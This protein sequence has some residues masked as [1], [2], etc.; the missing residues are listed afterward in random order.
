MT[1]ILLIRHAQ[2]EWVRSGRLAGWT[3]GVHLNEEG[4]RQA[5][6]LGERLATA[7]LRAI[8]SSPLERA[9]ET[10]E[11][12]AQHNADLKVTIEKEIG[13]VDY[14]EWTGMPLR[15][16]RRWRLWKVVQ[17]YPS[18]AEFPAGESLRAMQFR[19][20][21]AIERIAEQNPGATVAVV[22]HA[23]V[24]RV[25]FAHYAGI[26]LDLFQRLMIAPASITAIS[27][28]QMGPYILRMNDT[29]HYETRKDDPQAAS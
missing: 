2:N 13:E 26:H 1:L 7:K 19:T 18:G 4:R 22:T 10:A 21:G 15:K 16:L 28:H 3:P 23:D 17:Q 5:E 6:A 12:I 29:S 8:Y 11:A 20:V 25:V 14:G 9:V 24:I 27:L